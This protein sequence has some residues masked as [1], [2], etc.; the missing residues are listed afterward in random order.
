M[1]TVLIT[2]AGRGLGLE[3]ARQYAQAGWRVIATTRDPAQSPALAGAVK[4]ADLH[5]L[6]VRDAAAVAKLGVQLGSEVIDVFIANAGV[7]SAP[8]TTPPAEIGRAAWAEAFEVNVVAPLTC[9]SAF[10]RQVAR[11]GERKMIAIGSWIGSVGANSTGGHYLYRASKSA[12]NAV[13]RSF[14]VDHPEVIATVLSPGALRTDMTRYDAD[15]WA[16]LPEPGEAIERLRAIIAGLEQSDSGGF[17]HVTGE[18]LPW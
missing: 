7:M 10:L 14:A 18:R 11:S 13:W 4:P 3:F 16:Q 5:R 17:I 15:R 9:A 12:L 1:P 2:G 6:D 8:P